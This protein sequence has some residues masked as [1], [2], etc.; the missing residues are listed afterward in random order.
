MEDDLEY[1]YDIRDQRLEDLSLEKERDEDP[2][3]IRLLS[4]A[5]DTALQQIEELT[6]V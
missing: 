6:D 5:L 1:W 2:V 3:L 4:E